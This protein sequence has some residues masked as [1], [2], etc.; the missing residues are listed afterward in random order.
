M[1]RVHVNSIISKVTKTAAELDTPAM[2]GVLSVGM[3]AVLPAVV[4][5]VPSAVSPGVDSSDVGCCVLSAEVVAASVVG[6][7]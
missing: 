2:V 5:V 7:E 3:G 4:A 1:H 6:Q